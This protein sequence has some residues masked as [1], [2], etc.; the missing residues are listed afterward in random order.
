MKPYYEYKNLYLVFLITIL[1][2]S[3]SGCSDSGSGNTGDTTTYP[4]SSEVYTTR[5]KA[6]VPDSV[7]SSNTIYPW[8]IS[9]FK[10]NGYG[11]W[12]YVSGI[13]AGKQTDLM[14]AGYS[15]TS[16]TNSARLLNF[17]TIT[18]IHVVDKESPNQLIYLAI[19]DL[20]LFP[21]SSIYSP[22]ML[23]STHVLDA[24]IQTVNALHKQK[25]FDCGISLGDASNNTQYNEL[26]WYIDVIDG[27][28]ITPSSGSHAGA[29]TID[30][31]KS[32]R[33]AGLDKTIPWY[34]AIGNHDHF[35]MGSYP[36]TDYLRQAYISSDI[37]K[38]GDPVLDPN[39]MN[40]RT[41]YMGVLDGNTP[42]G[43][44][45]GAG[46]VSTTSAIKV[47]ADENRHSLTSSEKEWMNEFFTTSSLPVGHGFSQANIDNGFACYSFEPKSNIPIKVIMLDDTQGENDPTG[48]AHASLDKTRYEW[49]VSEL[50][51]GQAEGKL[52]IIAAHA[53]IGVEP[54]SSPLS[55]YSGAYV[56]ETQLIAKLQTYSNFILWAA[57]HRHYN[58]VTP[59]KSPDPNHPEL[60][61][62]EVETSSLRDFPQQFRTFEIVRN[63]DNTIS[64]ITTDVDPAVR[65][66]SPAAISRSYGVAAQQI[67]KSN[68]P[69]LPT[70]SYNAE[71][72]K[73]LSPEMQAKIQNYGTPIKK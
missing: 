50:D 73:Q 32:Y 35:W 1:I 49:L 31:Q 8:E 28:V 14:P 33:A 18:D 43:N 72:V 9:K 20:N 5:Q 39:G 15:A 4:I 57:G 51:K 37:I 62:W 17:F 58:K 55:W 63:S 2:L 52:M 29:G 40:E 41:Y 23:Y 3:L 24:A 13:D 70:A 12:H 21:V 27:K 59:F 44:I 65:D 69:Q 7:S 22:V 54:G 46:P 45:I 67:Y 66:G 56:S 47:T 64:I 61:F 53:P 6:I 30:Y 26:R 25:T 48:Y 34:Q 60:G 71:L 10:E 19:K 68:L 38:L 42:Y 16:V 36:V 11:T